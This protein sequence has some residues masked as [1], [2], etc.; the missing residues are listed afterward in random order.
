MERADD[1]R[2]PEPGYRHVPQLWPP[3]PRHRQV[4]SAM[5]QRHEQGADARM[6]F[7][8][9]GDPGT[10]GPDRQRHA[11]C[12]NQVRATPDPSHL[13]GNANSHHRRRRASVELRL[14]DGIRRTGFGPRSC[15]RSVR[16]PIRGGICERIGFC[17]RKRI[18][19]S[20]GIGLHGAAP[21]ATP[22]AGALRNVQAEPNAH[23]EPNA[24]SNAQLIESGPG[25]W[26]SRQSVEVV[27]RTTSRR[28]SHFIRI[29]HGLTYGWVGT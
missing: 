7:P 26:P 25:P 5:R 9:G 10:R 20:L 13:A 17:L 23:A 29:P 4:L 3:G 27:R 15:T 2:E 21:V 6:D 28:I 8:R 18:R 1:E 22:V 11:Q 24:N 12:R 16:E 14:H 19:E